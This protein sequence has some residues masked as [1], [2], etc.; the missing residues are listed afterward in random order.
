[1]NSRWRHWPAAVAATYCALVV[2]GLGVAPA[3][4]G[5][6]A[7]TRT[8][9]AYYRDESG[10]IRA[11][12]LLIAVSLL[13]LAV[14][15]SWVRQRLTGVGR[16]VS[17]LGVAT[18]RAATTIELWV[19]AGLSA[20]AATTSPATVIL[21]AGI[22]AYFTPTLTVADLLMAVPVATAALTTRAFPRW[23]GYLS[24][25][26]AIEQ[27]VETLTLTERHGFASAG[28]TMNYTLGAGLF[29][30]WVAASGY[31]CSSVTGQEPAVPQTRP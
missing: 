5:I 3:P 26:F 7:T 6:A 25:A 27:A 30:V 17:L 11:V 16:A 15:M 23:Y 20:H 21:I 2:A 22:A 18:F 8:V 12:V 4:P 10:S 13:P 9:V 31:V 19:D 28:G 29:L 1:M 14:V 24:L